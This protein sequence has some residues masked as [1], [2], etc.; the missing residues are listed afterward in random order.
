VI[1]LKDKSAVMRKLERISKPTTID[2]VSAS[3]TTSAQT[4]K[5]SAAAVDRNKSCFRGMRSSRVCTRNL[6]NERATSSRNLTPGDGGW[7]LAPDGDAQRRN[8]KK[9]HGLKPRLQ[10]A[11]RA[12]QQ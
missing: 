6:V 2:G 10:L 11:N 12:V 4:P 1:G 7:L 3:S 9:R 8:E 5:D